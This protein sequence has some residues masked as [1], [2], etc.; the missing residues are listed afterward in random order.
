MQKK[1]K[2]QNLKRRYSVIY[3]DYENRLYKLKEIEMRSEEK[4]TVFY[5][6]R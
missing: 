3:N 5:N 1:K 6:V 4:V 2:K